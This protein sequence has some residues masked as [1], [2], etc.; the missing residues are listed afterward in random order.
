MS[1]C[2]EL[3]ISQDEMARAIKSIIRS[4]DIVLKY[5]ES[6]ADVIKI[7]KESVE[8]FDDIYQ[9]FLEIHKIST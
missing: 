9:R 1:L 5:E 3:E 8:L 6:M 7:H 4:A 2:G